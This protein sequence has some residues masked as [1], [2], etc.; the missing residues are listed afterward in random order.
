MGYLA[1]GILLHMPVI[2]LGFREAD[3]WADISI[4]EVVRGE[5]RI[6]NIERPGST[7]G[8]VNLVTN[9]PPSMSTGSYRATETAQVR[10]LGLR[11]ASVDCP[12]NVR[13][14]REPWATG[15]WRVRTVTEPRALRTR[16]VPDLQKCGC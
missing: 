6:A 2:H 12:V 7:I 3:G 9:S 11:G 14:L 16:M 10:A 1:V 5:S 8:A 4:V 13:H 15:Q